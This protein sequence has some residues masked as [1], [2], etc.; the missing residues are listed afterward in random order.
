MLV[1]TILNRLD[2][3]K[4]FVY[5]KAVLVEDGKTGKRLEISIQARKNSRGLCSVC[6]RPGPSYDRLSERTFH[7]VPL[8]GIP[9]VFL[10][11]L[12]RINCRCCGVKVEQVP[13][14]AG[15]SPIT[16]SLA[17]FLADWAKLLCWQDV[18]HRF[19]VNWR[20]VFD[21]VRYVVAWGL[22]HRDVSGV[23]AIG[24]DEIQFGRGHQY[25]TVIYQLLEFI[26][27]F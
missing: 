22:A 18:A 14:A 9:V 10:Y 3:H 27:K 24:V 1:T 12:R 26:I 20:Q 16:R 7:Y 4:G 19:R 13:W 21:S 25:L 5:G 15:K 11:A 8:W 2:K 23:T 17:L 6:G